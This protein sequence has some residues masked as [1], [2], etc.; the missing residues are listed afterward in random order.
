MKPKVGIIDYSISNLSSVLN[1]FH[2]IG[3]DAE[4][5]SSPTKIEQF[6]HIVLP[7]VGSFSKGMENLNKSNMIEPLSDWALLNKPLLGLC[8]GMQLLSDSSEEFG[9]NIGLG[10]ISGNIKKIDVSSSKLRLPHVGW[11]VV[12][13]SRESRLLKNIP[14]ESSFYF[15]HSYCYDDK[16]S[17]YVKA[18]FEYGGQ[19]VAIVE[20]GNIFGVQF[21]PEKSQSAG[22]SLLKNFISIQ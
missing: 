6:T 10:L 2:F 11:N 19:Q 1:A 18:I 16:T 13:Q 5:T 7:G 20:K 8:L 3:V 12:V 14:D 15:V 4:V 9:K 22:L 21:H 17:K